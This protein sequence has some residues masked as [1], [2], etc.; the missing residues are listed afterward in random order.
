MCY[1][2]CRYWNLVDSSISDEMVG[3]V[4]AE[5]VQNICKRVPDDLLKLRGVK[6]VFLQVHFDV[7]LQS[8]IACC[9]VYS[10]RLD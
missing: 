2:F 1:W 5:W 4:A 3:P 10:D 9:T 8:I 7:L 6:T